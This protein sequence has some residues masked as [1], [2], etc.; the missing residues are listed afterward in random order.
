MVVFG[1]GHGLSVLLK[2]LKQYPVEITAVV[3]V[4]DDGSSTG[5][6]RKDFHIPAVGDIRNVLIS[7]SETEPLLEKLLQ[8]RFKGENNLSGHAVGNLLLAALIDMEGSLTDAVYSLASILKLKGTVL[9]LTEDE[10]TL[11]GETDGGELLSGEETIRKSHKNIKRIFYKEEPKVLLDVL[12]KVREADL[13]IFGLGSLLTSIIPHLICKQLVKEIK[14]SHAKKMYLC[15][16]MTE[17]GETNGFK[18]SD[19]IKMLE[20][21]LGKNVLDVVVTNSKHI[22]VDIVEL[23]KERENSEPVLIDE[24][25]IRNLHVELIKEDITMIKDRMVRHDPI[26][27]GYVIFTY[28]IRE[29]DVNI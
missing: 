21:Y 14:L 22:D 25:E 27:T 9:P 23:Y 29:M 16:A 11:M 6:L 17:D 7:L 13:I 19:H 12:E 2:G 18:V 26:K 15:N 1:G 10:V 20:Q 24:E 3:S 5:R 28:I 4:A 8:Y